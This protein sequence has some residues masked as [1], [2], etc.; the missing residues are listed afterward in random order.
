MFWRNASAGERALLCV[1][2]AFVALILLIFSFEG[3]LLLTW[4]TESRKE[5]P[6]QFGN[7][8]RNRERLSAE[9][10]REEFAFAVVG[11]TR[12]GGT[13]DRIA[14]EL[15]DEPLSFAVILG[16]FV[17]A[18]SEDTHRFFRAQCAD[19]LALPFPV[20]LIAGNHDISDRGF[21]LSRF[22][23]AYGP[24]IFSFPYQDCLF[25]FLRVLNRP[26]SDSDSLEY[27]RRLIAEDAASKYRRTFVFMHVPPPISPD[28][29][30]KDYKD[31]RE[32]V[33]LLDRLKPD[34]VIAG[35]YH[36]YARVER[37]GAAYLVTGGG[38]AP[39]EDAKYGRFHH[40]IVLKIGERSVSERILFVEENRDLEDR[41]EKYALTGGAYPWMAKHW[42]LVILLNLALAVGLF[43]DLPSLYRS[44]FRIQR[45]GG[46]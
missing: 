41:L 37:D 13:F 16:D 34:Y 7:F 33:S 31:T 8:P 21:P 18:A 44:R 46:V 29:V 32:L 20:F 23:E 30:A 42:F 6:P 25:V 35:D 39:L 26:E 40:A 14:E 11:D 28:F 43:A 22:E 2:T 45:R 9:K 38:G 27:L 24:T 1:E 4:F 5:L 17:S 12:D 10:S 3:Y 36:G 15:R 19:E